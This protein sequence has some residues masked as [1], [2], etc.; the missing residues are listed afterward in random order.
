MTRHYKSWQVAFGTL[1]AAMVYKRVMA[2]LNS[3]FPVWVQI[4][5]FVFSIARMIPFVQGKIEE[6]VATIRKDFEKELLKY[7]DGWTPNYTLPEIG[8]NEKEILSRVKA[9]TDFE[10]VDERHGAGKVSGTIYVGG[11]NFKQYS[12]MLT[13]VYGKFAWTNPLHPNVFPGVRQMESEV[14]AM[15]C[16]LFQGGAD[17]CGLMTSGGTESI[18]MA[19]KAYRDWGVATKGITEPNMVVPRTAHPAFEKGCQYFGIKMRK[20][21]EHQDTRAADVQAMLRACDSNTIAMVGS[22]PQY[23]HGAVDPIVEL[24]TGAQRLGIGLHV[25]CCLGSFLVPFMKRCGYDFPDFDFS[26]PGVTTISCDTHKYG[27]APKGSSVIMYSNSSLRRHQYSVFPDWPGGVYG[28]PGLA[29]SR[30]GALVAATWA[31]MVYHGMS[32]YQENT[33]AIVETTRFIATGIEKIPGL[34]L[35]CEP[36]VSIVAWTSDVFDINRQIEGLVKKRGWD[37]NV[38]QFPPAIHLGVTMAHVSSGHEIAKNFL[39]DLADATAPLVA[40]P[41]EKSAGAAAMYGMA[42]AVPDRSVIEDVTRAFIDTCSKT[43]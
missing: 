31:A 1:F 5:R 37:V 14:I 3:E 7:P 29:G 6:E 30:P 24:A 32:G 35:V 39:A 41:N 20:I 2:I 23:P 21:D 26:V 17:S 43:A 42:Q 36:D 38:L 18:V 19:I 33:K 11:R 15:C 16:K 28:T 22:A 13:H 8:F 10:N 27:F 9:L 12:E 4:K 40:T 34:K 25:D